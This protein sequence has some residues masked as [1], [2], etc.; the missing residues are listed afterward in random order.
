ML[1][2]FGRI[3]RYFAPL[4]RTAGALGLTDDVALVDLPPGRQLVVTTDAIV[5]GVH[6]LPT[7]PPAR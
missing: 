3:R 6:F 5:E 4:A 7:D 1:G 2:E